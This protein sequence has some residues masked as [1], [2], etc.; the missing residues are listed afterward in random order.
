M[1]HSPQQQQQLRNTSPEDPSIHVNNI[2]NINNST[3][4]AAAAAAAAVQQT[5]WNAAQTHHAK[6]HAKKSGMLSSIYKGNADLA[7]SR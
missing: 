5:S 4:T 6:P 3:A 7:R 2:A 1:P